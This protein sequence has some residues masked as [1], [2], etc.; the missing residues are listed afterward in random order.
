MVTRTAGIVSLALGLA[1]G[2]L[3]AQSGVVKR[4][5]NLRTGPATTFPV[6]RLLPPGDEF[7]LLEPAVTAG[8]HHVVTAAQEV[9]WL[10]RNNIRIVDS[11]AAPPAPAAPT[12]PPEV[13]H[14][15][16]LDGNA[17]SEARRRRN[18]DKNR[19]T[20]PAATDM[21]TAATLAAM[22]L[23]GDDRDRWR[24]DRGASIVGLVVEVKPGSSE[25]VNCG[26]TGIANTDAHIELARNQQSSGKRQRVIVEVSPRWREFRNG[27]GENWS[28]AALRTAL[29][30]RCA[31][32]TGWLFFDEEHDDEA[33]NTAPGGDNVWRA[34]AW[35]IHPVTSFE[36]VPCPN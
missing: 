34:T 5:V 32:F 23:S 6:I 3:A 10:W 30:G 1:L 4:N 16:P 35:E 17:Q 15:C 18:R 27:Q 22:L 20:V 2:D 14:G 28:T 24:N 21:D 9:G 11:A 25:T 36:M 8:Y 29:E 13:F 33:E 31:R 7:T 12:G 19:V 26:A